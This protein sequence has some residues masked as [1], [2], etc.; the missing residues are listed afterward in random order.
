MSGFLLD[1]NVI[2]ELRK[3]AR[4]DRAVKAWATAQ[5]QQK[6]FLSTVVIAEIRF[7]IAQTTDVTFRSELD[8]WLQDKVRP[9][10]SGRV[11]TVG[12][13]EFLRWREMLEKGRQANYTFG[14]PDLFLAAQADL[15]GLTVVTRNVKDF[16]AVSVP[17]LNPWEFKVQTN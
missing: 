3:E 11:L 15:H 10:F 1:T 2:S 14:Q 9:W 8:R 6:V 17:V 7:G 16:T 12:E 5:D 4:C 13:D